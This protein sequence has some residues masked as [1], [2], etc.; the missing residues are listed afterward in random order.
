MGVQEFQPHVVLVVTRRGR[1]EAEPVVVTA[2]VDR[3][4]APL[5]VALHRTQVI[6]RPQRVVHLRPVTDRFLGAVDDQRVVGVRGTRVTV[7]VHVVPAGRLAI[8]TDPF[9]VPHA[10]GTSQPGPRRIVE[11]HVHVAVGM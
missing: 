6:R 10:R 9:A 7:D 8:Q 1:L 3:Q 4:F 5:V 11:H 2:G